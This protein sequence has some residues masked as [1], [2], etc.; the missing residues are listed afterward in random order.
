MDSR[1]SM[2]PPFQSGTIF[3]LDPALKP[4]DGDLVLVNLRED[5]ELTLRELHIDPPDWRLHSVNQSSNIRNYL[6]RPKLKLELKQQTI[7]IEFKT[8]IFPMKLLK[9]ASHYITDY[10]K[11]ALLFFP[12]SKLS[13][14]PAHRASS[15]ALVFSGVK[16]I[17][18][19]RTSIYIDGF[20]LYYGCLKKSSYK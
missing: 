15:E 1:P 2:Y 3:I 13:I 18:T 8:L 10:K 12:K 11:G 17:N 20:N 9:A 16:N 6:F 14:L 7:V 5:N 19:K 4:S